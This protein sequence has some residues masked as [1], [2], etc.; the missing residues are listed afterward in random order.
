[1]DD[2]RL[3]VE[4]LK[5]P[6]DTVTIALVGKY[7]ELPDAYISVKE[8]LCHAALFHNLDVKILGTR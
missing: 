5:I 1:L 6:K 8:A 3:M 7:V 4:K 2:W